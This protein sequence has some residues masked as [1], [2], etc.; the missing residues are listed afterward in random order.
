MTVTLAVIAPPWRGHAS[1][2]YWRVILTGWLVLVI[3]YS[4]SATRGSRPLRISSGEVDRPVLLA[5]L[6]PQWP[7]R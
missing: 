7:R 6:H 3:A 2:D 5:A 4:T 1:P